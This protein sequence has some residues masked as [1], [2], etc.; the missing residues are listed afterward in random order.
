MDTMLCCLIQ[1][2]GMPAL[3]CDV[4]LSTSFPW[5][6]REGAAVGEEG[7]CVGEMAQFLSMQLFLFYKVGWGSLSS[8]IP[9][10]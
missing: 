3:P 9:Y 7:G 10:L 8:V 6:S 4:H 5:D 2:E 1:G